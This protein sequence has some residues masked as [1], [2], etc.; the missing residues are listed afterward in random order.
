MAV[1]NSHRDS[2]VSAIRGTG[3]TLVLVQGS[4]ASSKLFRGIAKPLARRYRVILLKPGYQNEED[5]INLIEELKPPKVTLIGSSGGARE[6]LAV[7]FRRPEL[8]DKIVADSYEGGKEPFEKLT[9]PVLLTGS[10]KDKRIPDIHEVYME[11]EKRL[12]RKK[13]ILFPG[14]GHP[15]MVSNRAPFLEIL[16]A[17][18][19]TGD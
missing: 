19:V 18:L 13:I 12:K 5:I 8:V 17:F 7:G 2:I 4:S 1:C 6:V 16:R 15:A 11:L 10:L 14:G 3:E 9:M